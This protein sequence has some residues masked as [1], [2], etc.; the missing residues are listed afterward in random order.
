MPPTSRLV[1]ASTCWNS[2]KIRLI[3]VGAIP[4]PVSSTLILTQ[5]SV[6]CIHLIKNTCWLHLAEYYRGINFNVSLTSELNGV[7]NDILQ[8]LLNS[9]FVHLMNINI[10]HQNKTAYV[11]DREVADKVGQGNILASKQM[12]R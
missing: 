10:V 12:I 2:S 11:H 3:S 9:C 5:S 7:A 6:T 1:P 8:H 4:Q